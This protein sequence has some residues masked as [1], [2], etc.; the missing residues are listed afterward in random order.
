MAAAERFVEI[1]KQFLNNL[2]DNSQP[3]SQG[4]SSYRPILRLALDTNQTIPLNL[5]V[6][7]LPFGRKEH[8]QHFERLHLCRLGGTTS[9]YTLGCYNFERAVPGASTPFVV[10]QDQYSTMKMQIPQSFS[11]H[12]CSVSS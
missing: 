8:V 10:P 6:P 2:Q 3:R 9:S 4:L 5:T 7:R 12:G 1:S 11:F